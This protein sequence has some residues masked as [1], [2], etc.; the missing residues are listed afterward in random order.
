MSETLEVGG[1]TFDVRRSVRRTTLGLTV[2]RGG[3]LVMHAPECAATGELTRWARSRLLWVHRKLATKQALGSHVRAPEFVTGESFKYLGRS[4]RLVIVAQQDQPLRYDGQRFRL[5]RDARESAANHFRNWYVAVG[6][7]W[8]IT[9]VALLA[10][11]AGAS[12]KKTVLRDLGFRWG[13]C[14]RSGVVYFNWKLLQLPVRLVDYVIAHELAHLREPHHRPEFWRILDATL[15]DW[16]DR[17][18]ELKTSARDI[19]WCHE[20]MSQ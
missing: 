5:R 1:L 8:I 7:E 10:S 19:Y 9:R 3:E 13:S 18:E 14:G 12:P 2:D 20:Q 6:G 11:R 16:R 4:H 17:R 15:P